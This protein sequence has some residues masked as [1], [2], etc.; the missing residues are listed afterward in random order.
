MRFAFA[1]SRTAS[2]P[3]DLD[4]APPCPAIIP[5]PT[6]AGAGGGP[7]AQLPFGAITNGGPSHA[8]Q[9]FADPVST[10]S[11]QVSHWSCFWA[12]RILL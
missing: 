1:L 2:I 3:G 11:E 12:L 8:Q 7:T 9:F 6:P 4:S 5:S 10:V